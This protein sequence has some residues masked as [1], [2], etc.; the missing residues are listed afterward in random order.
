MTDKLY[1]DSTTYYRDAA[2]NDVQ[3]E[4]V[5]KTTVSGGSENDVLA[6]ASDDTVKALTLSGANV[7]TSGIGVFKEKAVGAFR[8]KK[9]KAGT[10]ITITATANDEVEIASTASGGGGGSAPDWLLK[11]PGRLPASPD[12][13]DDHFDVGDALDTAGTRRSGATAWQKTNWGTTT[14]DITDGILRIVIPA[15]SSNSLRI[16]EQAVSGS[17]WTYRA[18]VAGYSPDTN[19]SSFGM[20]LRESSGGKLVTI[21][22][23]NSSHNIESNRW[24]SVTSYNSSE[25]T[26]P[27]STWYA[28][29]D[30]RWYEAK[31]DGT[32][33][34]LSWS[35][36]G[37]EG[38]FIAMRTETPAAFLGATPT[39]VGLF[40][41]VDTNANVVHCYCDVFLKV[42]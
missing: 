35:P 2:G 3:A 10:D 18:R 15:V 6:V 29:M 30:W 42:A 16:A 33:V 39:H 4:P 41:N 8:F 25:T 17:T 23:I 12:A 5:A 34:V 27:L 21:H 24:N 36:T 28:T 22:S 31:Y 26:K 32:N 7:G 38:S 9:L 11:Q 19:Y 40:A 14:E 13:A 37:V 20:A 1:D